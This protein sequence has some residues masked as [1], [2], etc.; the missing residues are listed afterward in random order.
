MAKKFISIL[1]VV[2]LAICLISGGCFSPV[3]NQD[4]KAWKDLLKL[5]PETEKPDKSEST[6]NEP[7]EKSVT[8]KEST[9]IKLYFAGPNGASLVLEKR[10]VE[11]TEGIA[12]KT[13]EE[14]ING[15]QTPEN[16]AVFPE[17]TE[18]RDINIKPDGLCIVDLSP[19][20]R[21]IDNANQEKLMI[22]SMVNTLGQFPTVE[23]VSFMI[24]GE[25]VNYI[26]GFMDVSDPVSP[27]YSL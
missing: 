7:E 26:A 3:E 24:N 13:I 18:L 23:H 8:I 10:A 17:G 1:A 22:Y 11:K 25:L 14:L 20:I 2:V 12:R 5:S 16:L 9:D 6:A 19:D 15:P 27:D 4:V 21:Q